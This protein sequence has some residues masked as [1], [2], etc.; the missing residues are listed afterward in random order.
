MKHQALGRIGEET[1]KNHLKRKGFRCIE[2]NYQKKWGEIDLILKKGNTLHFIEVKTVSRGTRPQNGSAYVSRENICRA[3]SHG[4][5]R[6][7]DNVD[8]RKLQKLIRT[9]ETW[10]LERKYNGEWQLDVAAVKIDSTQKSGKIKIIDNVI[11]EE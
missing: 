4:T 7:E 10:M 11:L 2:Q 6:P 8:R 1:V 3:V 9:A 5:W